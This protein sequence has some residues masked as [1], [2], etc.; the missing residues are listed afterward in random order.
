MKPASIVYVSFCSLVLLYVVTGQSHG[1]DSVGDNNQAKKLFLLS[2]FDN[3]T[4][5]T[6]DE[7]D[8]VFRDF[9]NN[10]DNHVRSR[11]F[12]DVWQEKD[13]GTLS[14]G[15]ELFLNLDVNKDFVIDPQDVAFIFSWFDSN[16]DGDIDE[17]EFVSTL[18]K[19]YSSK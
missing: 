18:I 10:T 3:N 13:L 7:F 15:L 5:L 17:Q 16:D 6:V 2:D 9:D 14:E 11:E 8:H 12:L 1:Q 4:V 19:V